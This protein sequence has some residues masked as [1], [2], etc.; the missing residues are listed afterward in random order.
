MSTG[1]LKE[2]TAT[3]ILE[4]IVGAFSSEQ[5]PPEPAYVRRED[6][7]YLIS[8]WVPLD[9]FAELLQVDIPPHRGYYT[10]AGLVLQHF[11]TVPTVGDTFDFQDWHLE[12]VDLDGRRID[13]ILVTRR[14]QG[15][16]PV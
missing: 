2:S 5:G 15:N 8:G 4:S 3:D 9:E 14:A 12:V 16:E 7:S 13:K 10:V 1:P 6:G 11:G